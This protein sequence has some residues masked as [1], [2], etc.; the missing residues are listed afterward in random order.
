MAIGLTTV[1]AAAVAGLAAYRQGLSSPQPSS[2]RNGDENENRCGAK[3][4]G[5][6]IPFFFQ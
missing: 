2:A 1:T 3:R 6:P 4:P 5:T